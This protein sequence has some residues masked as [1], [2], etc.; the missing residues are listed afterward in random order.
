MAEYRV[1]KDGATIHKKQGEY[2]SKRTG[3]TFVNN[4]SVVYLEGDIVQEE[5][6]S[7]FILDLYNDGDERVC[8][9]IEK[10]SAPKKTAKKTTAKKEETTEK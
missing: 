6:I 7:P 4:L 9:L 8:S 5:D 3:K 10:V 2:K 1:L